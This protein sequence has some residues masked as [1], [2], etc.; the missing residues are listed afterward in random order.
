MV[1]DLYDYLKRNIAKLDDKQA[2]KLKRELQGIVFLL[3]QQQKAN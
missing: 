2:R 3:D 1:A